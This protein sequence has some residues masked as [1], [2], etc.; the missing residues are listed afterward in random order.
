MNTVDLDQV[1]VSAP[2]LDPA[3]F[4]ICLARESRCEQ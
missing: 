4:H 2:M 1:G 3:A